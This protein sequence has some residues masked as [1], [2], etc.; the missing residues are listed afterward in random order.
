MSHLR[1]HAT[2]LVAY[3]Q[4]VQQIGFPCVPAADKGAIQGGICLAH[5]YLAEHPADED[6]PADLNW[7]NSLDR[8]GGDMSWLCVQLVDSNFHLMSPCS[9]VSDGIRGL[10]D[11]V[12]PR[13]A[14]K[15][16]VR[17]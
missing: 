6:D 11:Y 17:R 14:T 15:G 2:K 3:E 12:S 9:K 7:L 10:T 8:V 5:A 13:P 16:D 4:A 1:D